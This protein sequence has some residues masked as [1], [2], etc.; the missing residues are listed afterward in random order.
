MQEI[1]NPRRD[2]LS[3]TFFS[4]FDEET[5]IIPFSLSLEE[6]EREVGPSG[7]RDHHLQNLFGIP[8]GKPLRGLILVASE[9]FPHDIACQIGRSFR[10]RGNGQFACSGGIA[11]SVVHTGPGPHSG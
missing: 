2:C 8:L 7:M 6:Y 3:I 1:Q 11:D 4:T 5:R 9:D 10:K